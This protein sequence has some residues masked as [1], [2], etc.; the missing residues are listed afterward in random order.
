MNQK[1]KQESFYFHF[2]EDLHQRESHWD[3]R[4]I[5]QAESVDDLRRREFYWQNELDTFQPNGLYEG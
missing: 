2:A 3:V 5:N 1:V 4:L